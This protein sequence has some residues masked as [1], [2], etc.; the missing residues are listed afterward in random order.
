M[1]SSPVVSISAICRRKRRKLVIDKEHTV[2][3]DEQTDVS[4]TTINEMDLPCYRMHFDLDCVEF[5]GVN[6]GP[7]EV[8]ESRPVSSR[9]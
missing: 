5:L 4:A 3:A 1:L 9:G 8:A 6:S 2:V 7:G